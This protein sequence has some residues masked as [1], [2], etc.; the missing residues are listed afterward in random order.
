MFVGRA[1]MVILA[2]G[3]DSMKIFISI[4]RLVCT[5]ICFCV[6]LAG[7]NRSVE[8]AGGRPIHPESTAATGPNSAPN[9]SFMGVPGHANRIVYLCDASIWMIAP[10]DDLRMQLR[11][12][13]SGLTSDQS[14]NMLFIHYDSCLYMDKANLNPATAENKR[15]AYEFLWTYGPGG[16]AY[17]IPAIRAAF[18]QNP[19]PE[20]IYL[21][22][23]DFDK[24]S[25]YQEVI[26]EVR[27]LNPQ[28]AVK[29]NTIMVK[30][31]EAPEFEK[32]L[33][34]IANENGGSFTVVPK[35]DIGKVP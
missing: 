23:H 20:L 1:E 27:K 14:F 15:N 30:A 34:T 18:A 19:H 3:R 21:L 16:S 2:S 12:A 9:C 32:A 22:A 31:S 28:K 24:V 5:L 33:R 10:F 4:D 13:I 8:P 29:I 25:S 6:L 26:D 11:K 17:P 7:C 35:N